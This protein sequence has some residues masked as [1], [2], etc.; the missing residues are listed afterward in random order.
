MILK[1]NLLYINPL[2]QI[3]LYSDQGPNTP[4]HNC[5]FLSG[6]I[7]QSLLDYRYRDIIKYQYCNYLNIHPRRSVI[8]NLDLFGT[9]INNLLFPRI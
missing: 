9:N 1:T 6:A 7:Q 5:C 3:L 4:T 8:R 2:I